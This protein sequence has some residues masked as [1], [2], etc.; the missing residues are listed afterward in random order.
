MD[1]QELV[2]RYVAVWNEADPAVRRDRIRSLWAPDGTTCHRLLEARGHAAIEA[3][4]TGS[5]EKWLREGN[6]VFRPSKVACRHNAVKFDWVMV[7][8]PAGDVVSP[9]LSFL[10]LDPQGRIQADYQ[11]NPT[12]DEAE[13]LVDRYL[14]AWNEPD[15]EARRRRVAELWAPDGDFL[16]ARSQRHGHAALEAEI[17]R[18]H[19]AQGPQG[20]VFVPADRS[21]QHHGAA[22]FE[23][24]LQGAGQGRIAAAG[25]EFLLLDESGRIRCDYRFDEPV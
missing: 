23:W 15:I 3:R 19:D 17:G 12:A 8:V 2:E 24:R 5:W 10:L 4:V 13:M 7:T 21:H 11:F 25:A 14:A 1:V 18:A 20:L 22:A 6:H 9:G 16:A